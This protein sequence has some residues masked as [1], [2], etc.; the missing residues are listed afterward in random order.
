M[1]VLIIGG[2][3]FIGSNVAE[4]HANRGD[5]VVVF[6]DLSRCG[7][8]L[9][10]SYL[11]EKYR[12]I[13]FVRGD[14]R[15]SR[16]LMPVFQGECFDCVYHEA[17]QVAVTTS[18]RDPREDFEINALGTFNVLEAMR[19]VRSN[20]ILLYAS[21]NK[22][23]G[24]MEDAKIEERDGRYQYKDLQDGISEGRLLDFHSP[25][26]CSKGAAE[27][28]VR[29]YSRIYNLK[30]IVF[31]QSC[32]YGYRQFG[33]ED[34]GWVAWFTIA[35]AFGKEI[36]I[37]GDGK[38]VRDVLF[39]DDLISAYSMAIENIEITNGQI[40]YIGGGHFQMSLLEL[41]N[42]LEKYI[43]RKIPVSYSDWRDGDQLIY[44]SNN[45]KA[46]KDFG[47]EPMVSVK[48]GLEKLYEWVT[49][50]KE[51]FKDAVMIK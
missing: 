1:I 25:Y 17:A 50:N 32:I 46:R 45:A 9:N 37:Y 35:A 6:D 42:Y 19:S 21:T 28:Y 30:T 34:Q 12:N 27:Q 43:G 14:I 2:A 5:K 29:D 40:Y 44:V 26:G 4:F 11:R 33:V 24:N 16:D 20:A 41:L 31:R 7:S 15:N 10:L 48:E 39:I 36:T 13:G 51:L 23:Y 22:V 49:K 18:V 38:Q 8:S 47:W 3:G